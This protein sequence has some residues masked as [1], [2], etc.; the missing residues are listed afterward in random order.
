MRDRV[1][2]SSNFTMSDRAKRTRTCNHLYTGCK[3]KMLYKDGDLQS[4]IRVRA[5]NAGPKMI[6]VDT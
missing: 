5:A 2:I 3:R 6:R 4:E 1:Q